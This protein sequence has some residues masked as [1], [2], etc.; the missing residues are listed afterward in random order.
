MLSKVLR[1]EY[2]GMYRTGLILF[3]SMLA[4]SALSVA[5]FACMQLPVFERPGMSL[6]SGTLALF[7][8]VFAF[9]PF[10]VAVV[11][12]FLL[13]YRFF[14]SCFTD[15]GYLTFMLP[16]K[17]KTL[18]LGK[19]LFVFLAQLVC[20][21]CLLLCCFLAFIV[22]LFFV[23]EEGIL[24]MILRELFAAIRAS[25]MTEEVTTLILQALLFLC[26][27]LCQL[28]ANII[29]CFVS[30]TIGST[31]MKKQKLL[32]SLLFGAVIYTLLGT[33]SNI[34]T[35]LINL[36]VAGTMGEMAEASLLGIGNGYFALNNGINLLLYAGIAVGG[37][38]LCCRIL[39]E[40]LNLE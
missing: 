21:L 13:L 8:F 28:A 38:F 16:A 27:L 32:G 22:P 14:A 35:L 30:V 4:S 1:Y 19:S 9:A 36:S 24:T 23:G 2:R 10:A 37:F 39:K 5:V 29:I 18:V 6:A 40:H 17:I 7:Y 33:I 25:L 3:L 34:I 31:L 15:E 11:F 12:F 26:L 20:V